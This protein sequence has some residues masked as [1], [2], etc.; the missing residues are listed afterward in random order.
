MPCIREHA[1]KEPLAYSVA[2]VALLLGI[3]EWT[4]RRQIDAGQI[5]AVRYRSRLLIPRKR[6]EAS[7]E[8]EPV[9]TPVAQEPPADDH[10]TP[11]C[12]PASTSA[13][14]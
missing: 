13:S 14:S 6:L 1:V 8:Q 10:V 11:A 3:S 12:S 5:P 4:V 2:E 7:V 9:E